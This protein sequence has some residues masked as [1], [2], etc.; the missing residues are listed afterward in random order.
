MTRLRKLRNR[1]EK[2]FG[3]RYRSRQTITRAARLAMWN[4]GL[5]H[6]DGSATPTHE[7]S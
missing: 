7:K 4:A 2:K 5:S 1:F 3:H 6:G